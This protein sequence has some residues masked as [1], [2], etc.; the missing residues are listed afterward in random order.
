M[1]FTATTCHVDSPHSVAF[2]SAEVPRVAGRSAVL[3]GQAADH[4]A[5]RGAAQFGGS[6][7]DVGGAQPSRGEIGGLP[8]PHGATVFWFWVKWVGFIGAQI[9]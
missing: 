2:Q 7:E 1:H 3:S 9:I 4:R 6:L 5:I 8:E